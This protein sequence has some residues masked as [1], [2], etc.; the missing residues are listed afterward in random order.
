MME[1]TT[2]T[3]A[4]ATE[5]LA[6]PQPVTTATSLPDEP[7]AEEPKPKPKSAP[8]RDYAAERKQERIDKLT[9]EKAELQRQLDLARAGQSADSAKVEQEISTRAQK[10]AQEEAAKI[11]AW[12][13]FTGALNGAI[14]KGQEEF[15]QEKFDKAVA[16]LRKVNDPKDP[17]TN[18]KYL[19]MLQ[20]VVDTGAAPKLIAMLGEDPN[21]AARIMSLNPTRMGVELGKL[22]V[23][24]VAGVSSAPK[25]I[26]PISGVGRNHVAIAAEDPERADSLDMRVWMERRGKHVSEVNTRAGRRIIP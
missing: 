24:D 18:Q 8:A 12:N 4:T 21:E 16:E 6:P 23:Q 15:G 14:A 7:V 11:A 13:E 10:I 17:E 1:E 19:N 9:A 26:T 3:E 20:A 22:A 2:T 25:P 5:P